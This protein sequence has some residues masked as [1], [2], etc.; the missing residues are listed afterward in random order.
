MSFKKRISPTLVKAE[1]RAKKLATINPTLDLG[2]LTLVTYQAEIAKART[3]LDHYNGLLTQA[4]LDSDQF[5]TLELTLKDLTE[6]TLTGVATRFGK[7]S[8]EYEAAGGVR[9][10]ERKKPTR[11]ASAQP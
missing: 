2:G 10:S 11:K 1:D 8:P 5:D 6:R 4:D 7:N 9:K 3:L